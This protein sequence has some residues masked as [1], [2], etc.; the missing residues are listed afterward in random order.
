MATFNDAM[1]WLS[2]G[3]LVKKISWTK[4]M[5]CYQVVAIDGKIYALLKNIEDP[6]LLSEQDQLANDWI[7]VR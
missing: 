6:Y 4:N 3:G 7:K 1:V 5:I 2:T